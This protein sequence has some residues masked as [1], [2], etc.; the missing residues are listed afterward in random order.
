MLIARGGNTYDVRRGKDIPLPCAR[1][2][3]A[4]ERDGAY[5]QQ[6]AQQAMR[7]KDRS[8][9]SRPVAARFDDP[10]CLTRV[11]RPEP[12]RRTPRRPARFVP[13]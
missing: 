6:Q 2:H 13:C 9:P 3:A 5:V 8:I 10:A 1:H 11:P 4:R 12:V 7:V